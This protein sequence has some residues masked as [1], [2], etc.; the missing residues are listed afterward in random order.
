MADTS[1][2]YSVRTNARSKTAADG[3]A[4]HATVVLPTSVCGTTMMQLC[5]RRM[6]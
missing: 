3:H 2:P 1:S 4:A 6:R 5:S